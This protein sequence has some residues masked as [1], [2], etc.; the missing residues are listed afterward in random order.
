MQPSDPVEHETFLRGVNDYLNF[1][2][3]VAETKAAAI[4]AGSSGTLLFLMDR[5]PDQPGRLDTLL[6]YGGAVLLIGA[7]VSA[8][9][10]VYP[11]RP[12]SGMSLVFWEDVTNNFTNVDQHRA[13]VEALDSES[14]GREIAAQNF[15]T[16]R[17]LHAKYQMIRPAFWLAAL[18]FAAAVALE[19][20]R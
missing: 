5:R 17:V 9:L 2:V 3:V 11:R 10:V 8:C 18:G 16:S 14:R 13:A 19:L 1:Y 6:V 20:T 7:I 15:Y 12:S 4:F